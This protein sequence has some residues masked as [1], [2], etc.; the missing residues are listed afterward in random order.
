MRV[1]HHVVEFDDGLLGPQRIDLQRETG[2]FIVYRA[3]QVYAFHLASAVDEA[4]LGIT[5]V[6]RGADL[7]ESSARQLYV[8]RTLHL[9]APRYVHLPLALDAHG[10]KLSKQTGA[11]AVDTSRPEAALSAVLRFLKQ[12]AP[13]EMEQASLAE[14]WAYAIEHWDLARVGPRRSACQP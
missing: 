12:P 9:R 13:P 7:L 11:Q 4:E 3:D 10:I 14:F 5:D 6:V 2:D 8:M 1:D